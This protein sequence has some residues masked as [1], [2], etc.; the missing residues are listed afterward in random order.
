MISALKALLFVLAASGIASTGYVFY[1]SGLSPNDWIYQGGS[2]SNW[3]NGGVHGA[4]GPI[5]GAGIP[6]AAVIGYGAYWLAKRRRYG[7]A[8]ATAGRDRATSTAFYRRY[9]WRLGCGLYS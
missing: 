8:G 1:N 4:P 2:P 7:G 3:T 5:A 9:L 6:L